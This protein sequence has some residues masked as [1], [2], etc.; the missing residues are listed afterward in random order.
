MHNDCVQHEDDND[1]TELDEMPDEVWNT[2]SDQ[3]VKLLNHLASIALKQFISYFFQ[4]SISQRHSSYF[5]YTFCKSALM[6]L[7]F[8]EKYFKVVAFQFTLLRE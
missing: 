6:G 8:D 5:K 3:L 1:D 2:I 4:G 7:P